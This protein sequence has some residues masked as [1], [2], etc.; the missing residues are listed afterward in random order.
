MKKGCC[1]GCAVV[2]ALIVAFIGFT[3]Y[4]LFADS[5]QNTTDIAYYQALSGETEGPNSLPILGEQI[6]IYCPYEMPKLSALEPCEEMHFLYQARRVIVFQSHSYILRLRYDP[7]G[8][9][10]QMAAFEEAYEWESELIPGETEGV[11]PDFA[12]DGY[13]FRCVEG[14]YYPKEMLCIGT[15]EEDHEIVILYFHDQDLDFVSPDMAV[16]LRDETCWS[17]VVGK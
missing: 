11:A 3:L 4:L 5:V 15:R 1:I 16:F 13:R 7:A 6:D 14:G 2:L 10:A 12:L 9:D 17:E 8:Y